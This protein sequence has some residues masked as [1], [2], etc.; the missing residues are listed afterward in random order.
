MMTTHRGTEAPRRFFILAGLVAL[1]LSA[2]ACAREPLQVTTIQ[3]GRQLNSDNTVGIHTTRFKPDQTMYVSV[4]TADR[5]AGTLEAKWSF[6]G[7]VISES[8]KD[9]SYND[10]AATEFH[11]QYAGKLPPGDYT[12]ELFL[13]GQSIGTR[14]LRVEP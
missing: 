13:D 5:G 11:L 9:V 8:K 4:I 7:R 2:A 14:T 12:V 1:A 10:Q 6:G 3:T